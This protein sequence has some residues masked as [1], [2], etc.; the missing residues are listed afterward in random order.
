MNN[1]MNS[2]MSVFEKNPL[3]QAIDRMPLLSPSER[4]RICEDWNDTGKHY[5]RNVCLHQLF[6]RQAYLTPDQIAVEFEQQAL[7]YQQL[8]E[9]VTHLAC[10]LQERGVGPDQLVGVCMERSLEMVIGIY[11]I[12]KAGG[13]Y[14]PFDPD[15]PQERLKFMLEDSEVSVMLGNKECMASLPFMSKDAI[16]LDQ[17]NWEEA[18]RE[19]S[20]TAKAVS[21]KNLAYMIYTSGSTGRPKGVL[22]THEA[23][24]NRIFW[25]QDAF[26]LTAEDHV[27]Q[28][29][30]FSFD[31]SVWEFFW[32]LM[33]GAKLVI[34]KPEGHKDSRYL[35]EI[36]EEKR[37]SVLHFVPTM[38]RAFLEEKT[39]GS[40]PSLRHVFCSGEALPSELK[41][42]FFEKFDTRIQLHNLY[43]PTEAAVDVTSWTCLNTHN[44]QRVPIG[45]P[46]A[47][48]SLYVLDKHLQPVPIG[49][50]G[51]LHIGGIGLARGYHKRPE[52]T[53]EKF[54]PD[55]FQADSRLYK[56]GDLARYLPDGSIDYIGRIDHQVKLRGNR[57]ELGEIEAILHSHPSIRQA[58]A[59][60]KTDKNGSEKLV[61]YAVMYDDPC[62]EQELK[63]FLKQHLPLFMIPSKIMTVDEIPLLP[64]G[65]V[66]RHLLPEPQFD[67]TNEPIELS[68]SPS[69]ETER[70]LAEIWSQV[71]NVEKIGVHQDFFDLGGD[72]ILSL[73][74]VARANEAGLH[75]TLKQI[76]DLK[77]IHELAK[78]IESHLASGTESVIDQGEVEGLVPLTP[79]QRFFFDQSLVNVN[80]WNQA[81]MLQINQEVKEEH[82]H[83]ALNEIILHHDALR[84]RF[85]PQENQWVQRNLSYQEHQDGTSFFHSYDLSAKS[86]SEAETFMDNITKELQSSLDLTKGPLLQAAYF[87]CAPPQKSRLLLIIH[88]L[89]IDGVSWRILFHDLEK[90]LRA[91]EN[92]ERAHVENKTTSFKTYAESLL[93]FAQTDDCSRDLSYWVTQANGEAQ[94][95]PT[96]LNGEMTES[97]KVTVS[98][99]LSKEETGKLLVA[100]SGKQHVQVIDLLMAALVSSLEILTKGAAVRIDLEG[101]GREPFVPE[102]DLSRTLGW[103]TSIFPMYV[104]RTA[105]SDLQSLIAMIKEKRENMPHG[106]MSYGVLRY[107][108]EEEKLREAPRADILFNYLGQFRDEKSSNAL[109]TPVKE[110][111]PYSKSDDE[112]MLYK[113]E[114][115]CLVVDD[116]LHMNW[117]YSNQ[118]YQGSTMESLADAYKNTLIDWIRMNS[119]NGEHSY[120][121]SDFPQAKLSQTDLTKL[122]KKISQN[123][124]GVEHATG[125]S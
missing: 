48:I 124:G 82:V 11:A 76:F 41:D 61:V 108:G 122:L 34:A 44:H 1:Q 109:L 99:L 93:H 79:I 37:I 101:H 96:D 15:Y 18:E 26:P 110:H 54:I 17:I 105:K 31:V 10:L 113:I 9:R 52:L 104:E 46:I 21:P 40:I 97:S 6:E 68:H 119:M 102:M 4:K 115:N 16:L 60:V 70:K 118:T 85:W 7:T 98:R 63:Q 83:Q 71:L 12:L 74:V 72:S 65:K 75:L 29:T 106:G 49:V 58:V 89:V 55:P 111:V 50:T 22:V 3:D 56:T 78:Q 20:P 103:F 64:N 114:I 125:K 30:P 87:Q 23:I 27:L 69:T 67:L 80:H 91:F 92:G 13:A 81:V 35:V 33:C 57:I 84:M 2:S 95:L 112:K 8:H 32:P 24:C 77:T 123:A 73:Q 36:M 100:R 59:L 53:R 28:K 47:N 86:R 66:N 116:Q 38:L 5:E 39:L 42:K 25:M 107:V 88:H 45:Y 120:T 19:Q 14:V 121:P 51:E 43:G 94:A 62:S 90:W 117:S